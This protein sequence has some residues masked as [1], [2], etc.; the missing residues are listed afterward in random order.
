MVIYLNL[1]F[2]DCT[3]YIFIVIYMLNFDIVF[4]NVEVKHLCRLTLTMLY[5]EVGLIKL[6]QLQSTILRRVTCF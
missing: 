1:S 5:L 3:S 2:P 4:A 6:N